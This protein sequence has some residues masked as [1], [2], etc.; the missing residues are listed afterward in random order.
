MEWG[1]VAAFA[2]LVYSIGAMLLSRATDRFGRRPLMIWPVFRLCYA[3][4]FVG[5]ITPDFWT[6]AFL[7]AAG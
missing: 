3:F 6:L 7:V 1:Y 5:A 2:G 4:Q